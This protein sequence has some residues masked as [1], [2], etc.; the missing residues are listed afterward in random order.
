MLVQLKAGR[1]V[2]SG[3]WTLEKAPPAEH[4]PCRANRGHMSPGEAST[5]QGGPADPTPVA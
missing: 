2:P 1:T 5:L 3:H 4:G